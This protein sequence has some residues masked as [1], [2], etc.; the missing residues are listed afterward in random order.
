MTVL[1]PQVTEEFETHLLEIRNHLHAHPELSFQEFRTA[2]YVMEKLKSFGIT[3]IQNICETGVIALIEGNNPD[4][5]C[6]ALRADLDALPIQEENEV[7]YKSKH[8]G[9]MHACGHD[10]HTT[11]LLGAAFLLHHTRTQW[12]GTVKL[13][14]QPGEEKSPGGASLLIEAGVLQYPKVE[15]IAGLHVAPD[16][17]AGTAGFRPGAYMASAD[18][19]H[20][21]IKGASGHAAMPHLAIDPI[22]IAS[23]IITS[24]QVIFSRKN[25][26]LNPSVLSFG[27]IEGGTAT[28]VIPDQVNILGTFRTFNERWR[29]EAKEIIEKTC[30]SITQL[31][32]ATYELK[33]PPGYPFL[34]NDA[35]VTSIVRQAAGELLGSDNIIDLPMRMSSED[36]SFYTQ[37]IPGTFFRLGTNRD[38]QEFTHSV[39]SS[40]FDIDPKAIMTG[41]RLMTTAAFALLEAG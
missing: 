12:Q 10:V 9:I 37:E 17:K 38:Q 24:L 36:F 15:A 41:V 29:Q 13:I 4:K 26:P 7:S 39:H 27:K 16:L 1:L 20:L 11:C 23:Q 30:A 18:E 2:A 19:I 14:F 35:H 28:N 25:N 31:Y 8:K 6:I 21:T 32:G 40:K 34:H 3:R 33:M 5:K 22:T